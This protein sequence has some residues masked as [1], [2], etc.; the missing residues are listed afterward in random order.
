MNST[1]FLNS[2]TTQQAAGIGLILGGIL[3]WVMCLSLA[4]YILQYVS[5]W[6][7]FNKAGEKGWKAIIPFYNTFVRYKLTWSKV[8]F[9]LNLAF[10]AFIGI[11]N[12][13]V[14]NTKNPESDPVALVL[15]FISLAIAIVLLVFHCIADYRLCKAYGKSGSFAALLIILTFFC[16]DWIPMLVLAFGKSQYQ[17]NVYLAKKQK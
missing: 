13:V 12:A 10:Y 6:K 14:T 16:L 7:L 17:G 11:A 15:S 9:W 2:L 1:N 4:Y 3:I 8:F 5:Y